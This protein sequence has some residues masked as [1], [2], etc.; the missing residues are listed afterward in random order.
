MAK[1]VCGI[2]QKQNVSNL[3]FCRSVPVDNSPSGSEKEYQNQ[4]Q[5]LVNLLALLGVCE[6]NKLKNMV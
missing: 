3:Q 4:R 2:L 6:K 1:G 5:S